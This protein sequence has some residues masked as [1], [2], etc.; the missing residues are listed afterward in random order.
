M[1]RL[2]AAVEEVRRAYPRMELGQ[3]A[4]LL[5]VLIEPGLRA[6]DLTNRVGLQKSSLSRNVKSLSAASY[7]SDEEGNLRDG[8][9]LIT[10]TPDAVDRR[11]FQLAPTPKGWTLAEKLSRI[12]KSRPSARP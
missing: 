1:R 5:S 2:L 6:Q 4:V 7:L 10:Q 8:L 3:L 12:L 9:D 11:A